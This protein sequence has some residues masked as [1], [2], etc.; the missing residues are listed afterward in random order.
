MANSPLPVP[1]APM[2]LCPASPSSIAFA[3]HT[4]DPR[5]SVD[6]EA[7]APRAKRNAGHDP[8]DPP[9]VNCSI[10]GSST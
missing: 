9:S 1:E 3:G 6:A 4:V 2:P 7:Q 10:P 8:T 5:C